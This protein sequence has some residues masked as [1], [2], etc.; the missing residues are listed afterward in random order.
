MEYLKHHEQMKLNEDS[1]T[2]SIS[3]MSK[4]PNQIFYQSYTLLNI[5]PTLIF[6][7]LAQTCLF[8]HQLKLKIF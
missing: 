1:K 6:V 2:N 4:Y 5:A 8:H 3:K 7:K